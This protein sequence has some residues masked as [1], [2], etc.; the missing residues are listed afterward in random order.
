MIATLPLADRTLSAE[1]LIPL[2]VCDE[3]VPRLLYESIVDR[4]IS[5]I[6][7]TPDEIDRSCQGFYRYW[8]LDSDARRANWRSQYGLTQ[9]QLEQLATR[10]LRIEKFKQA[11]WGDRIDSDFLKRKR[12]LDRAIYS[13]IRTQDIGLAIE[14]YFRILEGEQTFAELARQY[15]EG[16]E[17]DTNGLVGPIEFGNLNPNFAEFLYSCAPGKVQPPVGF[18]GWQLLLRLEKIVPAQLDESMRQHLLQDKFDAWL[19]EQFQQLSDVDRLW[20][21]IPPRP[22]SETSERLAIAQSG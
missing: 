6:H 17:A 3:L 20:M 19:K 2:L 4:A 9:A 13:L 12:Q 15:S 21:C 18:G 11:T 22:A 1:E 8:Q 16:A 5:Q 14:L 10:K 7:C